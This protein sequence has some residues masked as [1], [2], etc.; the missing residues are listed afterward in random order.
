MRVKFCETYTNGNEP[1]RIPAVLEIVSISIYD[2]T[3]RIWFKA[4]DYTCYESVNPVTSE[5]EQSSLLNFALERGY[6]DLTKYGYFM[7]QDDNNNDD[8]EDEKE[9]DDDDEA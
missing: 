6:V 4:E 5:Y 1:D 8:E 3:Q 2:D 9:E 7:S